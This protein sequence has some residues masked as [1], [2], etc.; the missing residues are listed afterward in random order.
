MEIE[1]AIEGGRFGL[2]Q[3]PMPEGLADAAGYLEEELLVA[4]DASRYR[5]LGQLGRDGRWEVTTDGSAPFRTRVL[6]RRPADPTRSNGVVVV[7]WLN[8]SAG[9]DSDPDFGL[10]HPLL[11]REG[12]TWVGVSTQATGVEG[13]SSLVD[14]PGVPK[15][16][17][18]SLKAADPDRYGSLSHPGDEYSYDIFSQVGAAARDLVAGGEVRC[19]LAIG[20][21]QSAMRM[22]TYL[23][24][25]HP[26]AGVYDGFL[27]HSRGSLAM[28][29]GA[30]GA[31]S[32]PAGAHLRTDLAEP[33]LQFE[34]ETDLEFLRF[35]DARQPD[36]DRVV[37]WEVAGTAH[38]DETQL[39]YGAAS[40]ARLSGRPASIAKLGEM[41]GSVNTGPQAQVLRAA[42][43]RLRAWALDG[44]R[45]PTAPPIT[46]EAGGIVR[47]D[48][49]IALGGI[50][51][52]PVAAPSTVLTG[53]GN[54]SSIFCVLFGQ[55]FP[56]PP[57]DLA[58]RYGSSE[59][60]V[61]AVRRS[62]EDAVASGFLL[63]PEADEMVTAARD[64][65]IG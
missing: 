35:L 10:L 22:A 2:P 44:E 23:N 18:Q 56:I 34:T 26:V 7:E 38:A 65:P 48:L 8:V 37:T 17:I 39:V 6:V 31:G 3:N 33:V 15:N 25:V 49:G 41:C 43:E 45:A 64:V 61:E 13:G 54:P 55:T 14:V 29:I 57:E 59:S 1:G 30:D 47:D 60:Y 50:R 20:E 52:P 28:A 11:L 42:M 24:A 19:V 63:D 58:A 5:A 32:P 36:N 53:V 21:S 4:G 46:T 27:V 9:R 62:A 12:Y 40:G 51:T 16:M